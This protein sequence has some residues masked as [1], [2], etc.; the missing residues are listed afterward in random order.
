MPP[1]PL[2]NLLCVVNAA[3]QI[4]THAAHIRA[5]QVSRVVN[6]DLLRQKPPPAPQKVSSGHDP[7]PEETG[8][9]PSPS[10]RLA[11]EKDSLSTPLFI[12]SL[13]DLPAFNASSEPIL[14]PAIP[15]AQSSNSGLA[16]SEHGASI[17]QYNT[18]YQQ[19]T[20]S[21]IDAVVERAET[22]TLQTLESSRMGEHALS[23]ADLE[24]LI[25][26]S[27][28]NDGSSHELESLERADAVSRSAPLDLPVTA[29]PSMPPSTSP[30]NPSRAHILQ[31]SRVPSSRIGRLFHYG[32]SSF[33]FRWQCPN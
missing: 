32:G 18:L 19:H 8:K 7:A 33:R 13:E 17:V 28:T 10:H 15:A 23:I 24:P 14:N 20:P 29:E 21:E 25:P 22:V 31:S 6:T 30:A 2:Y 12:H 9:P 26:E 3:G 27:D 4:L 5:G 1:S 11:P 16:A